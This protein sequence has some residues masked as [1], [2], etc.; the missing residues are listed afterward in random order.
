MALRYAERR[1]PPRLTEMIECVWRL[2]NDDPSPS[3]AH[4]VLPDGCVELIL[5]LGDPVV[6]RRPGRAPQVQPAIH[7]TGQLERFLLLEA[8]GGIDTLGVR[9]RP[10]AA[11]P[12]LRIPDGELTGRT[13]GVGA[14]LG[15]AGRRGLECVAAGADPLAA[16]IELCER[17]IDDDPRPDHHLQGVVR[18]ILASAGQTRIQRLAEDFGIAR[19]TLE[20]RFAREIGLRPKTLARIARLGG[21]LLAL[22]R[23]EEPSLADLAL[24][25]GFSDQAHMSREF[26][27]LAGLTPT[28]WLRGR[29]PFA[30]QFTT[31]A[32]L[33]EILL[34]GD[35]GP[36]S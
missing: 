7:V 12:L 14:L 15:D 23:R 32:R 20:R 25:C 19:R 24:A 4:R 9:F 36:R 10:G 33:H 17:R 13:V 35:P 16:L 18:L 29:H 21:T 5:Q 6:E 8:R 2:Q 27:D 31:E 22:T 30:S 3:A 1:P 11:R 28:E 26:R 34:R